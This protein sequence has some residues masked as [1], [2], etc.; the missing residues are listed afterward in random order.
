MDTRG[1]GS[2]GA[3]KGNEGGNNDLHD[4]CIVRDYELD[5]SVLEMLNMLTHNQGHAIMLVDVFSASLEIAVADRAARQESAKKFFCERGVC[6]P[7]PLH[8]S[9]YSQQ[10]FQRGEAGPGGPT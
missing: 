1:E 2:G 7:N 8:E 10:R 4:V 6:P 3:D 5:E 9:S